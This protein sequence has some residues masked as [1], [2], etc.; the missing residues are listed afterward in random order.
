MVAGKPQQHHK[1]QVSKVLPAVATADLD[2]QLEEE[3]LLKGID[4]TVLHRSTFP[5]TSVRVCRPARLGA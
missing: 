4:M 1:K 3:D 2:L 5:T